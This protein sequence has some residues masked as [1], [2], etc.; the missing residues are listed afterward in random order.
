MLL[1]AI[2]YL[3]LRKGGGSITNI[4]LLCIGFPKINI[5]WIN[6]IDDINYIITCIIDFFT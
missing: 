4:S 6:G 2:G 5:N 3:F 1:K